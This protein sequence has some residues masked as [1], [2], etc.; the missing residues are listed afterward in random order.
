MKSDLVR[1]IKLIRQALSKKQKN[2]FILA[3]FLTFIHSILDLLGLALLFGT[4]SVVIEPSSNAKW[5]DTFNRIFKEPNQQ[6]FYLYMFGA[7]FVLFLIKNIG[8][9]FSKRF[10]V[11]F[12]FEVAKDLSDALYEK[13]LNRGVIDQKKESTGELNHRINSVA[14]YFSDFVMLPT[15]MI[16]AEMLLAC[17]IM[18]TVLVYSTKLFLFM[19]LFIIPAAYFIGIYSKRKLRA[20]GNRINHLTPKLYSN[21]QTLLH[22]F[23]E[24]KLAGKEKQI[25]KEFEA[26]RSQLHASR[27]KIFM[28][29]SVVHT[30]FMETIVVLGVFTLALITYLNPEFGSLASSLVLFGT[31]AFRLIPSLNRIITSNNTLRTFSYVLD[32]IQTQHEDVPVS[33]EEIPV[34]FKDKIS[35]EN[36]SFTFPNGHPVL[37]GLSF[38]VKKGEK[39]GIYGASGSG[40]TTLINLLMGFYPPKSGSIHID[41]TPLSPESIPSWQHHLGYVRQDSFISDGTVLE[42]VAFGYSKDDID[43]SKVE[44]CIRDAKLS[45]WVHSLPKGLDTPIGELGNQISGG[46]RQRIAI[47]R[48]LYK[49]A[50][51][52]ILDEITNSLDHTTSAEVLN[53]VYHLNNSKSTIVMISHQPE[54]FHT[55]DRV[56]KLQ[57]GQLVEI[58]D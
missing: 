56:Y 15:L 1:S 8:S 24:L 30:H 48:M 5:L 40:K 58:N 16:I 28:Q 2:T 31:M 52:L 22:G 4:L 32:M 17:L 9:Y 44:R 42:N 54:E 46:Q 38:Q 36:V 10:Q 12:A 41:S 45:S 55:C 26:I 39:I 21:T 53:M 3:G 35:F 20:H 29:H 13:Q 51:L 43:Y 50:E 11:R 33:K 57:A 19:L 49:E 18:I 6:E 27:E 7:L 23:V 47:A 34:S 25:Q 14:I 37:Q